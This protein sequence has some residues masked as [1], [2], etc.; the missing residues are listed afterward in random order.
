MPEYGEIRVDYITYT[1][2]TSPNEGQGTVTVSGLINNPTFSGNVIVGND[3]TVSG[4]LN[5][6]G[7]T[8]TGTVIISGTMSGESMTLSTGIFAS[9]TE[10][11]PSITFI[12][13]L[14]T[15]IYSPAEDALG[16]VT[17]S[18]ERLRIN[19]SGNVGI[20]T[21]D[22]V[23]KLNVFGTGAA[24]SL[25]YDTDNLVNIDQ[26]GVQLAIGVDPNNPFGAYFQG[27]DSN[28]N[29][30]SILL[31]PVNGN[32]GIGTTNPVNTLQ[33]SRSN[34]ATIAIENTADD[35]APRAGRLVYSFSDGDGAAINAT[36]ATSD[37]ASDVNLS[38]RTGGITNSEERMRIDPDGNVG[39]GTSIP[40][41]LLHIEGDTAEFKGTNTNP[42]EASAGTE[43]I[44]K[45]GIEGQKNNVYGPA[46]SIIFRQD[47][48][49]WS[50]VEPNFKP[51]RIEFCT[52]DTATTDN[53]ETPRLVVD[54]DGN[55]GIG[56]TNPSRNLHISSSA[57]S[58]RLEDSDLTNTF[59]DIFQSGAAIYFDAR[60][61]TSA[62]QI[63][64]RQF[65][66]ST[67][68]ETMRINTAGRVGIGT[69]SPGSKL[70]ISGDLI[71]GN[72]AGGTEGGQITLRGTA[73]SSSI[74]FLDINANDA[75][76]FFSTVNDTDFQIGNFGTGGNINFFTANSQRLGITSGGN[77]G[78]GTSSPD[79]KF[80]ITE[81]VNST[82]PAKMKF[83]NAGDRGV[84]LGFLDHN[85]NPVWSIANGSQS[86]QYF[87]ISANGNV[88]I[89]T[90]NPQQLLEIA[91]AGPRI[92]ITDS[93]TTIATSTSYLEFYGSDARSA[94]I[95][96]NSN[97]LN[98]QTDT[99]SPGPI[100]F[101]TAG[102]GEKMRI[103]SNGSVGIGSTSP[104]AKLDVAGDIYLSEVGSELICRAS[105]TGISGLRCANNNGN[106]KASI[107]FQGVA[108]SQATALT[109][110]TSDNSGSNVTERARIDTDGNLGIGTSDPNCRLSAYFS[111][112]TTYAASLPATS[113]VENGTEIVAYRNTSTSTNFKYLLQAF[114]IQG[115]TGQSNV[116]GRF[117]FARTSSSQGAFVW[118][119]RNLN[120]GG[121]NDSQEAMRLT[122]DGRLNVGTIN[123]ISIN[124]GTDDGITIYQ[125][126]TS[127]GIMQMS[128]NNACLFLRRRDTNGAI[129]Q[130]RRDTTLVGSISVTTTATAYNTSSDYRLKENVVP[131]TNAA[132]RL[133]QLQVH[134][135]NFIADPDTTVNGFL[136][137]EAQ[138][139]VPECVTGTKDE[140][141]DEGNPVYQGIDQSK[142]VPLLT[143]ALQEALAKIETL[144]Q[145]LTDAGL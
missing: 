125:P 16:I 75:V 71:V 54:Q 105:N 115:G 83:E 1:T 108:S 3:L 31:N 28:N 4:T 45:F 65:N 122:N 88:G 47:N 9:G 19:S 90:T 130:F 48:S 59:T 136:A 53:S 2:G 25:T 129:A 41:E 18:T 37:T 64:F 84:V 49:T 134:R 69:S 51:T 91:S 77:V 143:A 94:I 142:M 117:G 33:V 81:P 131:L 126:G 110:R 140:V 119:I 24:P 120:G 103:T 98:I 114:S 14:N 55:V 22:P 43:Q 34:T 58:I 36:R 124:A 121:I 6:N 20:G 50:S 132:D 141:D 93:N 26:G 118:Q 67:Q 76:R 86:L 89:G 52:Q 138:A 99:G 79:T 61:N 133:N 68:I 145:R 56:T 96:T 74:G 30:R 32:V 78:I 46:G 29:S 60:S 38:F 82:T 40:D 23:G 5:A 127:A 66:G 92:R 116:F 100:R 21:N 62:G 44:F 137:H 73:G 107:S 57:G 97:G 111:D 135:F 70:D 144:E 11:A 95:F 35:T 27:R 12:D 112:T 102:S 15:G 128:N 85:A 39:I 113:G 42:I 17:N 123:N 87:N 8:V 106:E 101:V 7:M 13:D 80:Q 72:T 63:I 104:G 109:F 139:V 10:S